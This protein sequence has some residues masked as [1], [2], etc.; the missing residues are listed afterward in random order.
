[1]DLPGYGYARVPPQTQAHW[2]RLMDA[3]FAGRR[4]LA[5]LFLVVD[6]RR[7]PGEGD[8]RMLTW[9]AAI[10]CPVHLLLTKSDKVTARAGRALLA[11]VR[12]EGSAGLTVQLF[13]AHNGLGVAEAQRRMDEMLGQK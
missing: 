7:G 6:A 2:R 3:Y 12:E 9:A 4:S 13:S 10:R 1:V 11:A 5:G 8:Q